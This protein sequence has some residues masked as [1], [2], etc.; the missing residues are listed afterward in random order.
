MDSIKCNS[1]GAKDE[2]IN[3]HINHKTSEAWIECVKCGEI[4]PS[5]QGSNGEVYSRQ[6]KPTNKPKTS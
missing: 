4:T 1:C 2:L 3:L 5:D 6:A